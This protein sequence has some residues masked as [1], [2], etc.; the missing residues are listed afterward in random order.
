VATTANATIVYNNPTGLTGLQ[1]SGPWNLGLDFTVN[2]AG[3]VNKMGAYDSGL[4]GFSGTVPVAI[5]Y[6][7]GFGALNG[8]QVPGT[9]V[10]LA[11]S[12]TDVSG[13]SRFVSI[14]PVLLTPGVYS[15]VGANFGTANPFKNAVTGPTV[16]TFNTVGGALT[17]GTWRDGGPG[18]SY[19]SLVFPT[20]DVGGVGGNSFGT[21]PRWTAATFDFTPVPEAATFGAAAVGLLGLV[22]FVRY[23]RIRRTL[24]VA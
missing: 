16:S 3:Y 7:S 24:N 13:S 23:V 1:G 14:T 11:G 4:D 18:V 19:A 20:T 15:V 5:Y 9:V 17:L 8:T 12:P 6:V 10:N 22:Y 2:T 21:N